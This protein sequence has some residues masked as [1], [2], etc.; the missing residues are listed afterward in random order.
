MASRSANSVDIINKLEYFMLIIIYYGII[1]VIVELYN[2]I[3]QYNYCTKG[4][5]LILEARPFEIHC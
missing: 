1:M 3:R 4:S 5:D 2:S